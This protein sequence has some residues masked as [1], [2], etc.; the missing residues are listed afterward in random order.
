[1]ADDI[2]RMTLDELRTEIRHV[3][4]WWEGD[5]A[6]SSAGHCIVFRAVPATQTGANTPTWESCGEDDR[7]AFAKAL[8]AL[9]AGEHRRDS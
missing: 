8:R 2:D 9:R 5:S 1:M 4:G 6:P 3:F 7:D